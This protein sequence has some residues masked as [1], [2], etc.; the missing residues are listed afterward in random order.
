MIDSIPVV[1]LGPSFGGD[2]A[3]RKAVAAGID[4]AYRDIGFMY[5]VNHGIGRALIDGVFEAARRFHAEPL[6]AKQAIAMNRWHRG[7]MGHASSRLVT[8]RVEEARRP[9]MSES[10]M[11]M[12]EVAADDPAHLAGKPLQGP[13][14]WPAGL[15][16]FREAVTAYD[17]AL[18]GLARHLTTL[19]E[20]A[21]GLAPG[22]LAPLFERPTTFLRLLHYPPR[23]DDAPADEFGSA[24]HTDYGFITILAQDDRGGLEVQLPD[25][26]WLPAPPLPGSFVVNLADMGERLTNG[27]WRSTRHRVLN[28]AGTD[29]YSVPFFYD[30]DM[31]AEVAPLSELLAPG[32]APIAAPERY[33]DYLMAR[34]DANYAYR[35]SAGATTARMSGAVGPP[36]GGSG[37]CE[38]GRTIAE[39]PGE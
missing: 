35:Q 36:A 27:R 30:M 39:A 18:C 7:Y 10:F 19:V 11:L 17:N 31:E 38:A 3:E 4:R 1:D 2:M 32:A 34:L 13:N 22:R 28:R 5:I 8:S 21:L 26:R 9:N 24:P 29:R 6:E 15:P 12:H 16:R 20:L 14:L 23:H 25:G 33:G 37:R